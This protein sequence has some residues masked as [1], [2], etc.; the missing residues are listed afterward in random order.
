MNDMSALNFYHYEH[1]FKFTKDELSLQELYLLKERCPLFDFSC[2]K[3][4]VFTLP[5]IRKFSETFLLDN[6]HL[7]SESILELSKNKVIFL[8]SHPRLLRF[9]ISS[10]NK[11]SIAELKKIDEIEDTDVF[12]LLE[13]LSRSNKHSKNK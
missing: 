13:E 5:N 6:Y 7:L 1:L 11:L 8:T 2:Y 3:P 9:G 10:L 12:M 4:G